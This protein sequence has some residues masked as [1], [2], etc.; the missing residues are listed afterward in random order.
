MLLTSFSIL[1]LGICLIILSE[2]YDIKVFTGFGAPVTII[3][4]GLVL[5]FCPFAVK[6]VKREE[7]KPTFVYKTSNFVVVE[8]F[9]HKDDYKLKI[10]TSDNSNLFNVPDSSIIITKKTEVNYYNYGHKYYHITNKE[11]K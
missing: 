6:S 7:I 9:L 1:I 3:G 5:L 8:Y 4:I 2:R 10:L 11:L